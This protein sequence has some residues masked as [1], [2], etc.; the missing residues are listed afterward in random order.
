MSTYAMGCQGLRVSALE[1]NPL[2]TQAYLLRGYA[3]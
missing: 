2:D 1:T 3:I